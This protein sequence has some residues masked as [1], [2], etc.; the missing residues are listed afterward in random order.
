M[1]GI[2]D[3]KAADSVQYKKNVVGMYIS[4]WLLF[5]NR[6]SDGQVLSVTFALF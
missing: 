6:I 2:K 1:L 5:A 3:W 4:F